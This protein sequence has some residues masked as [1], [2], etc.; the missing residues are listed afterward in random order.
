MTAHGQQDA[1]RPTAAAELRS[2]ATKTT[3]PPPHFA[4]VISARQPGV[5]DH[6]LTVVV[7]AFNEAQRL[8]AT[9]EGLAEY[10]NRW[11]VDYRVLVVDDGSSDG[12]GRLASNYGPRFSSISQTNAGKGAAVR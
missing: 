10:L 6:D 2:P 3:P 8:P 1:H 9:L 12:T 5:S 7:P 4:P 11:G